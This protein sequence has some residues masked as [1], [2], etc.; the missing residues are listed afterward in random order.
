MDNASSHR[1]KST[2]D[3]MKQGHLIAAPHPPYSPDLAPCDF[4]LFGF[5]KSEIA[6]T[7]FGT[8]EELQSTVS[9][10][11]HKIPTKKLKLVY[12]NWIRRLEACTTNG[13]EYVSDDT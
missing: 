5:I 10:L 2:Q 1:A 12:N 13:G 4:F 6:E 8:I 7:V 3:S 11:I 9:D